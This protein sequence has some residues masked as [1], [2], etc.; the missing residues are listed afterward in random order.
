MIVGLPERIERARRA[1][2]NG[3]KTGE[4]IEAFL[5]DPK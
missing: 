2:L 1:R 5:D 3:A 4:M